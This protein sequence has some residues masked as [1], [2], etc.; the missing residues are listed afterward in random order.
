MFDAWHAAGL[1]EIQEPVRFVLG[2]SRAPV[3]E[4]TSQDVYK[5]PKGPQAF[6][7]RHATSLTQAH[8]PWKVTLANRGSY[9]FTLSRYPLY[10]DLPFG[11]GGRNMEPDFEIERVRL[12]IAGKTVEQEVTPEET[13]ASF[14]LDLEKGDADLE[15]WMIGDGKDATAYFVTVTF[16]G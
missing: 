1:K 2:D 4:L 6:S 13:H 3:V 16:N 7:Q 15:T 14:T 8:G 11:V 5:G 10:T 12:S 9:T